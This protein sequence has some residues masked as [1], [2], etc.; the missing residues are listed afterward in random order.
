MTP[1]PPLDVLLIEDEELDATL[2]LSWLQREGGTFNVRWVK[3]LSEALRELAQNAYAVMVMDL[4]LPDAQG[5]TG[6][7]TILPKFP[8][9]PVVVLTS[10]NDDSLALRAVRLGAQDYLIKGKVQRELLVRTLRYAVERKAQAHQKVDPVA[11]PA[12]DPGFPK[13]T[14]LIGASAAMVRLK[15]FLLKAAQSPASV[16]VTGESGTGK[17]LMARALHLMGPRATGPFVAVNCAAM[18]EA[19]LES[20][21][22]GHMRGAFTGAVADKKGLFLAADGGT[23]LLDEVGD[24]PLPLQAKLLRVLQSKT[25]RPVGGNQEIPFNVR[26]VAA[27][28]R[29]LAGM[30]EAQQFRQDLYFRLKVLDMHVPALRERLEDIA[31]LAQ[32]CLG[33]L[34]TASQAQAISPAALDLLRTYD[35]PGNV[36]ELQNCMEHAAALCDGPVIL[37]AD[38]PNEVQRRHRSTSMT[39]ESADADRVETLDEMERHHI[40]RILAAFDNNRTRAS[41]ALGISRRTLQRKLVE[42][43]LVSDEDEAHA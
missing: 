35:W 38:L 24:M 39:A 13:E 9:I 33:R 37:P 31:L 27:T 2:L 4:N 3:T 29:A 10:L 7:N 34:E 30:V 22:F 21:L 1:P 43:S 42:Y 6:L 19:L 11:L 23:L 8:R 32:H 20:E 36:R 40:V 28:H 26:V 17:E 5:L 15:P 18:P 16:L 14:G 12:A 41:Q 25:V